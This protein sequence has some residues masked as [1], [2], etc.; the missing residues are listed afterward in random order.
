[1][2]LPRRYVTLTDEEGTG[3]LSAAAAPDSPYG[4]LVVEDDP[5]VAEAFCRSLE[6]DGY[7]VAVAGSLAAARAYIA[8]AWGEEAP[9]A[10]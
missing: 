8:D 2:K 3:A 6:L 7:R 4:V 10:P 1:M 5:R 9:R